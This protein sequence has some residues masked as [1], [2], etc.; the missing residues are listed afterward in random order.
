M[1]RKPSKPG[2]PK[3]PLNVVPL[4]PKKKIGESHEPTNEGRTLVSVCASCGYTQGQ[5]AALL[6]ISEPTLRK[7]YEKEL[8]TGRDAMIAKVAGNLFATAMQRN[9]LK[10]SNTASIFILKTRGGWRENEKADDTSQGGT[11]VDVFL[12]IGDKEPKVA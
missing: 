4:P 1:A 8:T 3:A 5:I 11:V 2:S 6:Q 7:H 12:K 10:A 9:D